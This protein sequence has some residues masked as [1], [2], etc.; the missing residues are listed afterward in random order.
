MVTNNIGRLVTGKKITLR[1]LCLIKILFFVHSFPKVPLEKAATFH[2]NAS[3]LSF[4]A[5]KLKLGISSGWKG[6]S[7]PGL[8]SDHRHQ[9]SVP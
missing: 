8:W 9:F 5:R 2:Q 4:T 1:Y 3:L 6:T 7:Q